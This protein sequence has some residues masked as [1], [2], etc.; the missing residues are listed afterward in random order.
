M[1]LGLHCLNFDGDAAC[2]PRPINYLAV[3]TKSLPF[4]LLQTNITLAS[5][6]MS[7]QHAVVVATEQLDSELGRDLV[8]YLH[9][10]PEKGEIYRDRTNWTTSWAPWTYGCWDGMGTW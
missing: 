2:Y 7:S 1:E 10:M 3:C 6:S 9:I 5:A 4:L 8:T